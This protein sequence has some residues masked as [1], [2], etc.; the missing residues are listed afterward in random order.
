MSDSHMNRRSFL[1]IIGSLSASL[2]LTACSGKKWLGLVPSTPVVNRP[3]S[4][5]STVAV[6]K[7][8]TYDRKL[9]RQQVQAALDALGGIGDIV[10]PGASV[11]IKVNITGGTCCASPHNVPPTESYW[12][13]PE[14]VRALGELLRDAG[15]KKLYIVE[16]IFTADSFAA[17][18]YVDLAR[19]I[20]AELVDLNKPGPYAEFATTAVGKGW[21]TYENFEFNP[22]L[23]NVDA[24]ISVPKMKCHLDC[25]VTV[26]MKNLIGLGPMPFYCVQPTDSNRTAFHGGPSGQEDTKHRLPRVVVDLNRA[27][28]I[29]LALVDAITTTDGGE[30]PWVE[31]THLQA[32]HVLI[33]GKNAVATDAVATAVMGF[34]PTAEYP[35][36]PFLRGEN[37]LNIAR[38]LGLGTNRLD[39]IEIKGIASLDEVRQNFASS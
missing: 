30:G 15:A 34:D 11:A 18:G 22:V 27:R 10:K 17:S 20:N 29:H 2:Y 5:S 7:A 36:V 16:G 32:P 14:V 25:G 21:L 38:S 19:S 1:K 28:P 12:T 26:A 35:N 6:V 37:H 31:H 39:E 24:F 13:H 33:A 4:L 8:E 3:G 23:N 9:V